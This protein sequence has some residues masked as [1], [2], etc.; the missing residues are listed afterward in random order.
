[1][2]CQT[3]SGLLLTCKEAA[4]GVSITQDIHSTKGQSDSWPSE[5]TTIDWKRVVCSIQNSVLIFQHLRRWSS[6]VL[7][8]QDPSVHIPENP[9]IE[10]RQGQHT[11]SWL[12][13]VVSSGKKEKKFAS[14]INSLPNDVRQRELPLTAELWAQAIVLRLKHCKT[15]DVCCN[16]S[17]K[18]TR[19]YLLKLQIGARCEYGRETEDT[20]HQEGA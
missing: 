11:T 1:M 14:I 6:P 8:T 13:T 5:S 9:R 3:Y 18:A 4:S 15:R 20:V 19:K 10:T 17:P 2:R 16:A 7:N 12:K